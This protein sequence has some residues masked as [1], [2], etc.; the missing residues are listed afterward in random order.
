VTQ[1]F[2][3]TA[4]LPPIIVVHG[5]PGIGKTTF[6]QNFP[7]PVFVQTEDGCPVGLEIATFG[8]RETFA[9][10]VEALR[11]LGT[12]PHDYKTIVLDSLDKL[13]PQIL[14]AVCGDRGY[15]SIES[16]GYG[17]G[18]VEADKWWL[19]ILHG[20]EWLRRTRGMTIVLIAHSEIATVNDP[21]VASYTSYQLRLQKRARALV[22]D[23]AD[24]IGF[25][26]TDVIIKNEQGGFGKT[27]ARAD[28]GSTRWLH[29][30]GRP[31]FVAKNR[32]AMPERIAI[33]QHFD[34]MSTLGKFFPQP[35]AGV[36][37][38]AVLEK[39]EM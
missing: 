19:D 5:L 7:D 13:E 28:G 38:A 34:F 27:R 2:R 24:L 31:A 30:E 25:V 1:I 17:K 20:C 12:Q 37:T 39:M 11:H 21:R 36:T 10:V 4:K 9:A 14:T 15:A 16:P 18:W 6:A 3:A 35:Q 22:E 33:P 32:Y 26:A 23:T 29:V 8:L